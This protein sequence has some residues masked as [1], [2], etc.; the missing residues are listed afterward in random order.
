MCVRRAEEG[1]QADVLEPL[2]ISRD[3]S[4]R[5]HRIAV[6]SD[7]TA[8]HGQHSGA[9]DEPCLHSGR[10]DHRVRLGLEPEGVRVVT[11]CLGEHGP[12]SD[13]LEPRDQATDLGRAVR[14]RID[15]LRRANEVPALEGSIDLPQTRGHLLTGVALAPGEIQHPRR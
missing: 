1:N 8:H 9:K 10:R 7:V 3:E 14:Q 2:P 12:A 13:D 5:R 6:L 4:V 11:L 15:L